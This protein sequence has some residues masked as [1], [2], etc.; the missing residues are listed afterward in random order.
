MGEWGGKVCCYRSTGTRRYRWVEE[1][2]GLEDEMKRGQQLPVLRGL[3][4]KGDKLLSMAT[5]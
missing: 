1:S 4:L 5:S 2:D 3:R